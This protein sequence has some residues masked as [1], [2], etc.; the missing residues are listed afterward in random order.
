[1]RK[2]WKFEPDP[3][4]SGYIKYLDESPITFDRLKRQIELVRKEAKE[5]WWK[6]LHDSPSLIEIAKERV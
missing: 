6:N 2:E 1:M 5:K 3:T 4:T